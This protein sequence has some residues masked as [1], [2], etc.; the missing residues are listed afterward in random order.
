MG[1][2]VSRFGRLDGRGPLG[3]AA[4][5]VALGILLLAGCAGPKLA[6]TPNLFLGSPDNPFADIPPALQSNEVQPYYLTDRQPIES[7]YDA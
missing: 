4:P 5:V 1:T 6:D 2:V 7:T 3:A